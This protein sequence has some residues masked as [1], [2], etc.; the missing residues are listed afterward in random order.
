MS[1][2]TLIAFLV[3][4]SRLYG[5]IQTLA[6]GRINFAT[7]KPIVDRIRELFG[8][9]DERE[10]AQPCAAGDLRIEDLGLELGDRVLFERLELSIKLGDW[11]AIT[12]E[13]GAGKTVLM[14][15]LPRL[16]EGHTGSIALGEVPVSEARLG[17]LRASVLILPPHDT[18]FSGTIRDNV[19]YG[20]SIADERIWEV[21]D[22]VEIGDRIRMS[23]EGLDAEVKPLG[24][25]LSSGERQRLGLARALLREPDLLII[26]EATSSIDVHA[27]E[28]ILSRMRERSARSVIFIAHRESRP[29]LFDHVYRLEHRALVNER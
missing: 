29:G 10:G 15:L 25:E 27:E 11:V 18:L 24:T 16:I 6:Y 2:G 8:R 20:Q 26:D 21:L 9:D 5:P 17:A 19:T 12:G 23:I 3:L 4:Q 14:Q 13:N 7:N 28:R 1:V 22:M